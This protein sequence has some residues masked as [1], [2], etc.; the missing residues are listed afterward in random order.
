MQARRE[1]IA[2]QHQTKVV[3][4]VYYMAMVDC[5]VLSTIFTHTH[6]HTHTECPGST[7]MCEEVCLLL[8][9][10][11]KEAATPPISPHPHHTH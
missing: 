6:T 4:A 10:Y 11:D 1:T 8:V 2:L 5:R 7:K 3:E 9:S